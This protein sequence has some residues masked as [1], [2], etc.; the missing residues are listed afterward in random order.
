MKPE[1]EEQVYAGQDLRLP[2]V[3]HTNHEGSLAAL[4]R[5]STI[6]AERVLRLWLND[7]AT[8]IQAILYPAL[9]LLMLW[10]TL[11]NSIT[12]ATGMPSVYGTVPMI[13]LIAAMSGSIVSALGLNQEIRSGLVG[14]FWTMPIN[15]AAGLIGRMFA[16]AIRITITTGAIILVGLAI[17]F[18][19]EQGAMAAIALFGLPVIFGMGFAVAVTALATISDGAVLVSLVGLVTSLLMFFNTG[20]VPIF[21]YPSWLQDVVANQPMSCA[22]DAM[23]G[24]S[25]GGPVAEPLLKTVAWSFGMVAAFIYPAVRG[26]RRAAENSG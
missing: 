6:Q 15:R 23:R 5:D 26:Y 16:E 17:D 2:A 1:S 21:A 22:I 4:V 14:R 8:T 12:G 25:L 20:F 10:I 11:G 3:D 9:T 19:F 7:S 18:R 24:L 13:T